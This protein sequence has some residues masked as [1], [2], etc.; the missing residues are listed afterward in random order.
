MYPLAP[1]AFLGIAVVLVLPYVA[2]KN[3]GVAHALEMAVIVL[4]SGKNFLEMA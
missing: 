2:C 3:M 4:T 1:H